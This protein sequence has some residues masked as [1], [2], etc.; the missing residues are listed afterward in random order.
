MR[1]LGKRL[2]PLMFFKDRFIVVPE[3][4]ESV[5]FKS[6]SSLLQGVVRGLDTGSIAAPCIV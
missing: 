4:D 1:F 2:Q 3:F 5:S 6:T